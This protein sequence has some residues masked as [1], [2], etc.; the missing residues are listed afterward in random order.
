[1]RRDGIRLKNADPM[2]TVA[3]HIMRKRYDTLNAI[4]IDIPMEPM[5]KYLNKV[6]KQGH[7]MSHLSLILAAY[8]R[9]VSQFP[10][11]NRFVVNKKFYARTEL[12]VGMVVLK[13]GNIEDETISKIYLKPDDTIFDVNNKINDYIETSRKV[14]EENS[15]DKT[16][17]LL[18]KVP[19]LLTF[20][21]PFLMWLDRR[22]WLPKSLIDVSP[23]HTS[24]VISNL[25]SIKTNHVFHHCYD[26]G[27]TSL[28][29]TIGNPREVP[30]RKGNEIIFERCLPLGVVMDERIAT[31]SY[32]ATAFNM[33]KKCLANPEVLEQKPDKIVYDPNIPKKKLNKLLNK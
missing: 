13:A 14:E 8:V 4:T 20:G 16:I 30:K 18:L 25:A 6:R 12:P 27:T 9:T 33:F 15:T 3:A 24:M 11:L 28:V 17:K 22:G 10:F 21:I 5:R 2:Y 31:G 23:F 1:M 7:Y 32:F 29:I 26:F 19:G